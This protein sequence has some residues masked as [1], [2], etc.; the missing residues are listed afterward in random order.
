MKHMCSTSA[1]IFA[2]A[3]LAPPAVAAQLSDLRAVYGTVRD[4]A[5][6]RDDCIAW[7]DFT[8][9]AAQASGSRLANWHETLDQ[10][11]RSNRSIVLTARDE[12]PILS[13]GW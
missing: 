4:Q 10:G 5:R 8:D 1:R 9:L 12:V 11:Q 2:F 7:F 6:E 3:V 13:R